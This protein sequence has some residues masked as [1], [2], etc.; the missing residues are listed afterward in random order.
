MFRKVEAAL[1]V[2]TSC[3]FPRVFSRAFKQS[4]TNTM[5]KSPYFLAGS[6]ES[7][8]D[9]RKSSKRE[10]LSSKRQ[11]RSS[12][13]LMKSSSSTELKTKLGT[14]DIESCVS[15]KT[16]VITKTKK[17]VVRPVKDEWMPENWEMVLENIRS[18]RK[19]RDAPVDNMGAE[20]CAD[21]ASPPEVCSTSF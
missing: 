16:A 18:M 19:A 3:L 11:T 15:S 14:V 21:S 9:D 10:N 1:H 5:K 4:P 2:S 8:S 13:T 12:K 7:T 17:S 6:S 20:Q